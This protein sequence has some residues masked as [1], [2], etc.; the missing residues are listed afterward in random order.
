[1]S[2]I[3]FCNNTVPKWS[4]EMFIPVKPQLGLSIHY[5]S[6]EYLTYRCKLITSHELI[7]LMLLS[8]FTE[9]S[10]YLSNWNY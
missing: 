9:C 2:I 5:S 4:N 10:F 1:M 3:K 7:E 6:F 8:L